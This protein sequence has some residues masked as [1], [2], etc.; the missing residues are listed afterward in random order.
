M[1]TIDN[2]KELGADTAN[3]IIRCANDEGFYLRMV[4]LSLQDPNF[5]KLDET[6]KKGDLAGAFEC[7]HALKGVLGNVG[8]TSLYEPIAEMTEELRARKDIDYSGY[9][10]TI[11]TE[12]SKIRAMV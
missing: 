9:L 6:V 10:E 3:G 11:S 7:A 8:L 4:T 2:L 12:L 5:D 1:L